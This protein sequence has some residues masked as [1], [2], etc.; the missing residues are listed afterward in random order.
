MAAKSDGESRDLLLASWFAGLGKQLEPAELLIKHALYSWRDLVESADDESTDTIRELNAGV[1]AVA[2][3]LPGH[4]SGNTGALERAEASR[5]PQNIPRRDINDA[6]MFDSA[7]VRQL[8]AETT[9]RPR[10]NREVLS[11]V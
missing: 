9:A 4:A 8:L 2:G 3:Q 6:E 10:V 1:V 7:A 11:I 5:E